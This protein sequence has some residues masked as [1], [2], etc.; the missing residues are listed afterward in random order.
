M[1]IEKSVSIK[2]TISGRNYPLIIN[3]S[4]EPRIKKMVSEMNEKISE[5]QLK[6]GNKD[7]QD[8]L[9]MAL[10]TTYNQLTKLKSA[11]ATGTVLE[12]LSKLEENISSL[13]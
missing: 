6:Y 3:R 12:Q 2:V 7:R 1:T 8:H 11:K 10:L 4:E 13:L 9:A 5:F